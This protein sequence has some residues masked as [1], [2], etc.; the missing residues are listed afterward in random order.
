MFCKTLLMGRI[1][2]KQDRN[3]PN[4]T[5]VCNL[6]ISTETQRVIKGRTVSELTYHDV[7]VYGSAAAFIQRTCRRGDVVLIDGENQT[8]YFT[9]KDGKEHKRYFVCARHVKKQD[10]GVKSPNV[11]YKK[12]D[13][14]KEQP[15]TNT[16]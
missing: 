6:V 13:W 9:D 4:G 3:L 14:D 12:P 5:S 15:L 10:V 16:D 8:E 11:S 1:T 7:V 2:K